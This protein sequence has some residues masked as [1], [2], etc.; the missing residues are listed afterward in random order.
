M[1]FIHN[2]LF[3]NGVHELASLGSV[4][5]PRNEV[6]R[7]QYR[8]LF[9]FIFFFNGIHEGFAVAV[10]LPSTLPLRKTAPA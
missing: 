9:I 4:R 1:Q 8:H 6:Y 2:G 3:F 7:G 5:L 10:L